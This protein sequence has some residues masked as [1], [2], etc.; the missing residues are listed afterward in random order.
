MTERIKLAIQK[1]GRLTD[2]CRKIFDQCGLSLNEGERQLVYSIPEM[3][4][5]L[6]FVRDDDI[7]A[8]VSK[9]TCDF[10]IVGL[11]VF[12]EIKFTEKGNFNAEIFDKLGISKCRL[13]IAIPDRMKLDKISDLNNL[14]IATTYPE[15]VR[16]F[17]IEN[18]LNVEVVRLF[19]SVEIAPALGLSD[20]I[21]D[22][23]STGK[24]LRENNLSEF[25]P[26]L[27]SEAILINNKNINQ[28]KR[29]IANSLMTRFKK[30]SGGKDGY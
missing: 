18:N 12:Q 25:W 11:N 4:I 15:I 13:S 23:V 22:L 19:G 30:V 16:N 9:G 21:A 1:K 6:L 28:A 29:D 5:D 7:P 14:K 3:P 8:L 20:I 17:L 10:G 26:I 27:N 24:T 2:S